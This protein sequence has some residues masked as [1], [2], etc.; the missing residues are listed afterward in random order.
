MSLTIAPNTA[1]SL[2]ASLKKYVY[3]FSGYAEKNPLSRDSGQQNILQIDSN[4]YSKK[5]NELN[6][7]KY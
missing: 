6:Y 7:R 2:K 5:C 4:S 3:V 1:F